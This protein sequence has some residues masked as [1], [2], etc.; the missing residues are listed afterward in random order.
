MTV[1][2]VHA[3]RSTGL[4]HWPDVQAEAQQHYLVRFLPC[5]TLRT[6]LEAILTSAA[7]SLKPTYGS[8]GSDIDDEQEEDGW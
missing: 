7:S 4:M 2:G 8:Q 6:S 5:N 1:S 3:H